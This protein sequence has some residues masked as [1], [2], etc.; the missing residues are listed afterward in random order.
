MD[1]KKW[2]ACDVF[3]AL[4]PLTEKNPILAF[5]STFNKRGASDFDMHFAFEL[6]IVISGKMKRIYRN[7]ETELTAGEIWCCGLWEPHG[8]KV[9]K[10][11][12]KVLV[13]VILP[14][15]LFHLHFQESPEFNWMAPFV[16]H[17]AKRPKVLPGIPKSLSELC[18][19][20]E[21]IL[22]R[23]ATNPALRLRLQVIETLLDI[24]TNWKAPF[25]LPPASI[26]PANHYTKIA[27]AVEIILRS[28]KPVAEE[29]VAAKCGMSRSFFSKNFKGL[30]GMNFSEFALRYRLTYAADEILQTDHPIKSIAS[31]WGFFD[32]SHFL[33]Q[34]RGH[35]MC[36]PAEYR[37][38]HG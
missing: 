6:G 13:F 4:F 24:Q 31:N 27:K 7:W 32:V 18:E 12:C 21:K 28:R 38:R 17:P 10:T 30:M 3:H 5:F 29:E 11:P 9:I 36:T 20:I 14:Q 26:I 37:K 23:S 8:Y 33:R 1:K 19:K 2:D 35:Y 25:S 22:S 16:I 15:M 34:F